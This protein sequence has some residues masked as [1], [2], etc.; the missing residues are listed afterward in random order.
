M[1]TDPTLNFPC[2]YKTV[3]ELFNSENYRF[4]Q[5]WTEL[6]IYINFLI[7]TLQIFRSICRETKSPKFRFMVSLNSILKAKMISIG[8]WKASST[9]PRSLVISWWYTPSSLLALQCRQI[10]RFAPDHNLMSSQSLKLTNFLL[11]FFLNIFTEKKSGNEVF[12]RKS[13]QSRNLW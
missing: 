1:I 2:C 12:A 4:P 10:F 13:L 8:S 9:Y 5:L 3:I 7:F 6:K 11:I